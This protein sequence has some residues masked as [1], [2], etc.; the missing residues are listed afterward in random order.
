M[1]KVHVIYLGLSG[2]FS[3]T[4]TVNKT[5]INTYDLKHQHRAS[6]III[7]YGNVVWYIIIVIQ[8][9][10]ESKPSLIFILITARSSDWNKKDKNI[11]ITRDVC[12]ALC[13]LKF[14][15]GNCYLNNRKWF[16]II[17]PW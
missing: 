13:P 11:N 9:K 5:E 1:H 2:Q 12:K 14:F 4:I 8:F 6:N 15:W 10:T 3:Y 16:W 7:Q 17:L